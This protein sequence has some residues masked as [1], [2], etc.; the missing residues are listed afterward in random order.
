VSAPL[1]SLS[2]T[3]T[4]PLSSSLMTLI[5]RQLV[6]WGNYLDIVVGNNQQTLRSGYPAAGRDAGHCRIEGLTVAA[7]KLGSPGERRVRAMAA[8]DLDTG[9]SRVEQELAILLRRARSYSED[10]ARELH[11]ELHGA[12]YALLARL[13]DCGP[14]RASELS[15]Y[16]GIDKAAVSR[17]LRLLEELGFVRR[18]SDPT[19]G[20]AQQLVL[21]APGR[22]RLT[23][24]RSARRRMMRAQLEQWEPEDVAALGDLM[25]RFN[26]SQLRALGGGTERKR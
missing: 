9:Y 22:K 24:A 13:Q 12:S 5:L 19:D 11:P 7:A 1:V 18:E 8:N 15:S 10:I 21:T 25:G 20:R 14:T 2:L 23:R 26:E 17:Q 3:E 6:D 4:S 16:F